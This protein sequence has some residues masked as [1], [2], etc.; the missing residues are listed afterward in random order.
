MRW[1]A[2][3]VCAGGWCDRRLGRGCPPVPAVQK[4]PEDRPA[5]VLGEYRALIDSWLWRI[6]GAA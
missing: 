1:R 6:G 5:P 4:R 3:M 2:G